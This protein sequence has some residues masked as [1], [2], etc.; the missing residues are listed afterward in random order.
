M[1]GLLLSEPL[2][3]PN[4]LAACRWAT[5]AA[6]PSRTRRSAS[7]CCRSWW[8]RWTAASGQRSRSTSA[9]A[10]RRWWTYCSKGRRR[11]WVLL[12]P[13]QGWET[14]N[15]EAFGE[16]GLSVVGARAECA[17]AV[18]TLTAFSA[19]RC[20]LAV[21]PQV[22]RLICQV[23]AKLYSVGDQLPLY[24]RV[25][26]LQLF[27]GTR[28]AFR[29]AQGRSRAPLCRPSGFLCTQPSSLQGS[30]RATVWCAQRSLCQF[31]PPGRP[32]SIAQPCPVPMTTT[33]DSTPTLPSH[34]C[35]LQ[36]G[37]TGGHPAGRPG[38]HG[39]AVL[40]TR[41]LPVDRRAGDGC[42]GCQVLRR[43]VRAVGPGSGQ[44][45]ARLSTS[46]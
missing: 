32:A 2:R 39:S 9:A 41:A 40:C 6:V 26:S 31:S 38:V 12:P 13:G 16:G 4:P 33:P 3:L 17:A 36:Q 27:L 21:P 18:C 43:Q 20:R 10:R 28:E 29:W 1:R 46:P 15:W 7:S 24:S 23:L 8:S 37:Y 30:E 44:G 5:R 42:G 22:R 35:A 45:K 14:R 34:S 19:E 25:S 11:R